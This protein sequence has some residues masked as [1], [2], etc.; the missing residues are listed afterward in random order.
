VY[1]TLYDIASTVSNGNRSRDAI[2][3]AALDL[4][5][6]EG[7]DALSMRRL[8]SELGMG[9]MTLYGYFR[10]KGELL[11]AVIEE[12][13][14]WRRTPE[15]EGT[16]EDRLRELARGMRQA[17]ARHRSLIEVRLRRPIAGPKSFRGTEAGIQALL[18]AGFDRA[19]AARAFRVLFLYVFGFVAFSDPEPEVTAERRR[20]QAAVAAA[21]PPDEF[22]LLSEMGAEMA[23]TMGGD[24]QFEY[25]LD[26]VIAGLAARVRR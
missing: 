2:A 10:T 3:R 26:A 24:E 17:L 21:L 22:P 4:V 1:G 25:G 9:T 15:P 23:E 16:W 7:L 5:D 12:A 13:A 6:R 20:A 8:A 14:S 11:E 19:E 18:D